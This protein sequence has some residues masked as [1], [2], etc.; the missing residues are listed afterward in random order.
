MVEEQFRRELREVLYDA[1]R[2]MEGSR[3]GQ[4]HGW[5]EQGT[6]IAIERLSQ[7]WPFVLR[8]RTREQLLVDVRSE[9]SKTDNSLIRSIDPE[10]LAD[11][12]MRLEQDK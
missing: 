10:L 6:A 8:M 1:A 4:D 7:D 9:L 12:L 11:S 3:A 2:H 5:M